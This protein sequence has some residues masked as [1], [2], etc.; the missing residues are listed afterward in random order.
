MLNLLF[1]PLISAPLIAFA[2]SSCRAKSRINS[3]LNIV[4]VCTYSYVLYSIVPWPD[5]GTYYLKYVITVALLIACISPIIQIVHLP[6]YCKSIWLQLPKG[7]LLLYLSLLVAKI[8]STTGMENMKVVELNFPLKHGKFYIHQGGVN[9]ISNYHGGLTERFAYDIDRMNHLGQIWSHSLLE[10]N[11]LRLYNVYGDTI[12]SPCGGEVIQVVELN[13]DHEIGDL[14][15]FQSEAN[16]ITISYNNYHIE[17]LHLMNGSS[18]V[19]V[20]DYLSQGQPLAIVGNTGRS[21][22]PHLHIHAYDPYDFFDPAVV[23]TFNDKVLSRNSV[24]ASY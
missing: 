1:H 12:Y 4:T 21:K 23:I 18:M 5:Y 16:K 24:Y 20:G 14:Q 9:R 19:Q 7:I 15:D 22:R 13:K 8:S 6:N 11:E 3:A 17:I 2:I 10:P